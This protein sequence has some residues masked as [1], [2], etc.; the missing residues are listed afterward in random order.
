MEFCLDVSFSQSKGVLRKLILFRMLGNKLK[1]SIM[2][3]CLEYEYLDG[4][5]S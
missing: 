5:I 4:V 1:I 3:T 2:D